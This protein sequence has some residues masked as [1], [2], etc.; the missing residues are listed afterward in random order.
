VLRTSLVLAQILILGVTISAQQPQ[1]STTL[2]AAEQSGRRIFQTRCA[3]C[4]VGEDPAT[5]V[6]NPTAAPQRTFGPVLSRAQGDNEAALREKI[7]NGGPRMP[8][9]KLTLTDAQID[10]V[11][12]FVKTLERPLTRLAVSRPGQ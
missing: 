12:A 7:K 1:S 10:Q 8:G 9:Y 6:A 4:H 11:I 2:T 5:E 3:M